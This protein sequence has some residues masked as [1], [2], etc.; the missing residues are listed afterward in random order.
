VT[1]VLAFDTATAYGS[2]AAGPPGDAR[3]VAG[4]PDRQHG[5]RLVPAALDALGRIGAAPGDVTDL[6]V[7]DGPGSFTGLRIAHATARGWLRATGAALWTAPSLLALA[8]AMRARHAGPVAAMYDALRGEVFAAIV[9]FVPRLEM[10]VPPRRTTPD[11]LAN[12]VSGTGMLAVGEGAVAHAPLMKAW[13][14]R[15]PLGPPE[16]VPHARSFVELFAIPG[17]LRRI[18]EAFTWTPDYGRAAEAQVRWERA[19]GH[20]LPHSARRHT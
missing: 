7:G 6:V 10:V 11:A 9:R 5:A 14:G 18:D 13:T 4:I 15:A 20:A 3:A 16:A 19:H 2:V 8:W 1:L 17:A 12:E